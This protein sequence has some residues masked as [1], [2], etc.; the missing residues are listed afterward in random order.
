MALAVRSKESS[1]AVAFRST[2][3][4]SPPFSRFEQ[5]SSAALPRAVVNRWRLLSQ[6]PRTVTAILIMCIINHLW[7]A[8]VERSPNLT[9]A[10]IDWVALAL[11]E[12]FLL[13]VVLHRPAMFTLRNFRLSGTAIATYGILLLYPLPGVLILYPHFAPGETVLSMAAAVFAMAIVFLFASHNYRLPERAPA[14]AATSSSLGRAEAPLSATQL[15]VLN[16]GFERTS[17]HLWPLAI[18]GLAF[19]VLPVW[20]VVIGPPPLLSLFTGG[21]TTELVAGRQEALSQLDSAAMRLVIGIVRNIWA[22]FA[23]GWFTADLVLT[24]KNQWPY[25]SRARLL[26]TLALGI[27]AMLALITTERAL[28]GEM[29][30]VCIIAALIAKRRELNAQVILIAVGAAAVFPVIVGLLGASVGLQAVIRGLWRRIFFLPADVM[31]RYFIAFPGQHP[32]LEGASIP[33]FSTVFG[34]ENFNLPEYIYMTYYQR[35][36][37]VVGNANGSF[38][39]VGWANWGFVGVVAFGVL[40]A[41][42]VSMLDRVIDFLPIRSAAAMRGLMVINTILS[43][44]SDVF[45]SVLGFAPGPLDVLIIAGILAAVNRYRSEPRWRRIRPPTQQSRSHLRRQTT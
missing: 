41:I 18:V 22:M 35:M 39:G 38:F 32:H 23:V 21:S 7:T 45:R 34:G 42:A 5:F 15:P 44:S 10:P 20:V 17:E 43:S 12:L 14:R 16:P 26:L 9:F 36:P 3:S 13:G 29:I 31:V 8:A 40:A 2:G 24:P 33:K 4:T 6:I 37:G 25:R 30:G 1:P 27:S 19:V 11:A 28:L